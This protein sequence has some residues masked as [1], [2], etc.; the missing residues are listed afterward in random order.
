MNQTTIPTTALDA[1]CVTARLRSR[2]SDYEGLDASTEDLT[3]INEVHRRFC[4]LYMYRLSPEPTG[5]KLVV[6]VPI[7]HGDLA[8]KE[9]SRDS[10]FVDRPRLF[11]RADPARKSQ[12]EY[13]ALRRIEA[14]FDD[15]NPRFG[16]VRIYDI[17]PEEQAMVMQWIDQPSLRNLVYQRH[18]FG[19]A[20]RRKRL[21]T[22]FG[23]AGAWLRKHHGLPALAHCET[24]NTSRDEFLQAIE[25]FVSYLADH[26]GDTHRIRQMHR[27]IVTAAEEHLPA[28]IST[29]QV[30]G[31]FA[32]RNVFIDQ[33]SRVTV[34]DTLG[35]FEAPIY[36]DIARMLMAVKVCGPQLLS[37]GLLYNTTQLRS[38]EQSFLQGYFFDQPI[39][40]KIVRLF[41]AQLLLEHW[42]AIVYR[43]R[44]GRGFRRLAKGFRRTIWQIGFKSYLR[45]ILADVSDEGQPH[46]K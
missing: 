4:K 18:R 36:E 40:Y 3:L 38:Y 33:G 29:G 13:A 42:V 31:D 11:G 10:A 5:P 35:R 8:Y 25:R 27:Q 6:K 28:V 22:A 46:G 7:G 19:N 15:Q 9:K 41:E 32:P 21:E 30:H 39:P 16:V 20:Q 12:H 44:E 1:D 37:G 24:R 43:H 23:N 34:F 26:A 17:F 45:E 2:L 14:S